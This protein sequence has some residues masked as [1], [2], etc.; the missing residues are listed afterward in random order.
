MITARI[1]WE[2]VGKILYQEEAIRDVVWGGDMSG[3]GVDD[4]IAGGIKPGIHAEDLWEEAPD[5]T[6]DREVGIPTLRGTYMVITRSPLPQ[7]NGNSPLPFSGGNYPI[8][9]LDNIY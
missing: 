2:R 3:D 6:Q 5:Q 8:F 4:A 9:L 1:I 7:N